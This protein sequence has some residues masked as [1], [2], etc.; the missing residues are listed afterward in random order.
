[1]KDGENRISFIKDVEITDR[2]AD[3]IHSALNNEIEKCDGI[4]NSSGFGSD[5]AS[6]IIGH[7]KFASKSKK[8]NPKIV[9]IHYDNHRL[10]L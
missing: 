1:M 5:R 6:V 10:V 8:D 3:A 7:K 2:K 9:S 4:E